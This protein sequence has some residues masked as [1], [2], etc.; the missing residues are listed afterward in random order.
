MKRE[1]LKKLGIEDGNIIDAILDENGTD[2]E[3]ERLKFKDY[4]DIK[5]ELQTAKDT[6]KSYKDVDIA[7]IT[8]ERDELK[9]QVKTLEVKGT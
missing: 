4:E 9:E 2:L 1:F 5:E 6:L 3:R 7:E 8:K